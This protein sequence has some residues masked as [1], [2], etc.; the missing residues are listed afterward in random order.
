MDDWKRG[1]YFFQMDSLIVLRDKYSEVLDELVSKLA[2]DDIAYLLP[3]QNSG[4]HCCVHLSH[5]HRKIG[6]LKL[7]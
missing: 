6:N 5:G 4:P 2:R 1:A 3:Y 7:A